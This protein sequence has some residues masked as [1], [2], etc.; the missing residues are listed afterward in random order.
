MQFREY[1]LVVRRRWW[2]IAIAA[3]ASI[4]TAYGVAQAQTPIYRSSLRLEVSGRVDYGQIMAMDK[5]L[6]QLA[7]RVTT[8]SVAEA[9]DRRLQLGLGSDVLLSNVRTQA[10]TD[11]M[12]VQLDVDDVEPRRA[13]QIAAAFADVAQER[14]GALMASVPQQ[15]RVTLSP[16]DRPTAARLFSPQTRTVA[17]A[18]G[19]LGLLAGIILVFLLEYLDDSIRDVDDVERTLTLPVLGVI[20][21]IRR[22][23]SSL[24]RSL[25]AI[26]RSGRRRSAMDEQASGEGHRL[27]SGTSRVE[28]KG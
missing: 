8:T 4:G 26:Q 27:H 13:E 10:F 23:G 22:P 6:R 7:A 28:E 15:E 19:L 20:P 3:V 17:L 1:L 11:A 9:V 5:L 14:H 24:L 18:G 16:L 12:H 25:V 2:I 21:A